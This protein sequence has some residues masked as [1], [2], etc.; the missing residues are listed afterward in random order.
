M[1]ISHRYRP[2][3]RIGI[4]LRAINTVIIPSPGCV[5][6]GR[7]ATLRLQS[8]KGRPEWPVTAKNRNRIVVEK[9]GLDRKDPAIP[10]RGH[11]IRVV[12]VTPAN[13]PRRHF[14]MRHRSHVPPAARAIECHG[15]RLLHRIGR[16]VGPGLSDRAG[17]TINGKNKNQQHFPHTPNYTITSRAET[18]LKFLS[19]NPYCPPHLPCE[20]PPHRSQPSPPASSSLTMRT[21]AFSPAD[22]HTLPAPPAGSATRY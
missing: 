10:A 8:G 6:G 13:D 1:D 15:S 3:R 18:N 4:I 9:I 20:P 22:T 16:Q 2:E 11:E 17:T 19:R 14:G 5:A 21:A 7:T 12:M